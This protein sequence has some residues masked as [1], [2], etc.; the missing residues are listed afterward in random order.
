M[1][2]RGPKLKT[3]CKR[4]HDLAVHRKR[5]S[6]GRAYCQKCIIEKAGERYRRDENFRKQNS[7]Y[8]QEQGRRLK[9]GI[10]GVQ[11]QAMLVSQKFACAICEGSLIG[12]KI[13]VD[14]D[15]ATEVV[16]GL[17]CHHCN[18]ALGHFRDRTDLLQTAIQYLEAYRVL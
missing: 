10:D 16:R 1:G 6:G 12:V 13:C 18:V 4:G 2:K 5:T 11:F 3:H 7:T 14:H 15:H 9:Y 8:R 17:L